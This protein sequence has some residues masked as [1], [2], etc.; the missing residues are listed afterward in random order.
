MKKNNSGKP[1]KR[2]LIIIGVMFLIA[3]IFLSL[4]L[5]KTE[6]IRVEGNHYVTDELIRGAVFPDGEKR[7]LLNVLFMRFFG[8]NTSAGLSKVQVSPASLK[9]CVIRVTEE[10]SA[11][12]MTGHCIM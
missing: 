7:T 4:Y 5:L 6:E 8:K 10:P 12:S 1:Y 11:R 3:G 9:S 2:P